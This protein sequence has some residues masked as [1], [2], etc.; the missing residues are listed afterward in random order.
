MQY[1]IERLVS[2]ISRPTIGSIRCIPQLILT[3]RTTHTTSLES[4]S[5]Y[6]D[7]MYKQWS[8]DPQSVHQVYINIF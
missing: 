6:I 7:E 3:I 5:I 2:S 1:Y 8:Q 4:S